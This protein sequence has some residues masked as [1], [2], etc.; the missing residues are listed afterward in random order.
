VTPQEK[1]T[2]VAPPTAQDQL[3]AAV[4]PA[5]SRSDTAELTSGRD[6]KEVKAVVPA[7]SRSDTAKL[8][9]DRDEKEVKAPVVVAADSSQR[10]ASRPPPISVAKQEETP[11]P[12]RRL[13][14]G[15][16]TALF[17]SETAGFGEDG[18]EPT[19]LKTPSAE[20]LGTL[21][22][23]GLLKAVGTDRAISTS[24]QTISTS[25]SD[26]L[27]SVH[28]GRRSKKDEFGLGR[29]KARSSTNL[30]P[31]GFRRRSDSDMVSGELPMMGHTM[32]WSPSTSG[33]P[34]FV[35]ESSAPTTPK[36]PLGKRRSMQNLV[37]AGTKS[38]ELRYGTESGGTTG[39]D[40]S[41]SIGSGLGSRRNS[42]N[43]ILQ[44]QN[45]RRASTERDFNGN[46]S[47]GRQQNKVAAV[48]QSAMADW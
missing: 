17:E 28:A 46:D 22:Q 1:G 8:T 11:P 10:S 5:E 38:D 2:A 31:Q 43:K 20:L 37:S 23:T 48:R 39:S 14:N 33:S 6:E 24:M 44:S 45:D 41:K 29:S 36:T 18:D 26:P 15:S 4:V 30:Y 9:S 25:A 12:K 3:L 35:S 32:S 34:H 40:G 13:S 16:I 47:L 21:V 19:P 7:E 42:A 27:A